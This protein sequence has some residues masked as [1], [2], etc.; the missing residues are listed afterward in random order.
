MVMSLAAES[1]EAAQSAWQE[2]YKLREENKQLRV[3][4]KR[5][6]IECGEGTR[7]GRAIDLLP[8]RTIAAM[9]AVVEN[10]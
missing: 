8:K 3:L 1:Y 7:H 2:C 10:L 9:Q 4:I 5:V 6:L